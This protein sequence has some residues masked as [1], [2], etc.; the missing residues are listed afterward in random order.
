[1][2]KCLNKMEYFTYR[3]ILGQYNYG[4]LYSLLELYQL[5]IVTWYTLVMIMKKNHIIIAKF[6]GLMIEYFILNTIP[7]YSQHQTKAK[8]YV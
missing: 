2:L 1:M 5:S 4:H 6:N 8:L 7:Y 3:Y